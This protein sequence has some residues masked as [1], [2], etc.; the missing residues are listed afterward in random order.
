MFRLLPEG[1]ATLKAARQAADRL[2]AGTLLAK[3]T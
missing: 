2:A 3:R 1:L